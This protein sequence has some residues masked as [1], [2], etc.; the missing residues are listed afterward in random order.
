LIPLITKTTNDDISVK[1]LGGYYFYGERGL[2]L[3]SLLFKYT[4]PEWV[5]FYVN[6][7]YTF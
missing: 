5:I 7:M 6:K 2:F 1:T 4:L 3:A